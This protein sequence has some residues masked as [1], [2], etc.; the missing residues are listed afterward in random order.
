MQDG[1]AAEPDRRQRGRQP[2]ARLAAH[3]PRA[4]R[5]RPLRPRR[6]RQAA[7]AAGDE[8]GRAG[9]SDSL[10]GRT[11]HP[12]RPERSP[13]RLPG[14]QPG[15]RRGRRPALDVLLV[16]AKKDRIDDRAGV[17]A[18]TGRRPVVL[19]IEAFALANAYQMNYPGAHRPA[20]GAR[21]TSAAASRS[22]ACSN[23]ASRS[24]RATSPSAARC[25]STRCCA[26]SARP[27]ST[28]SAAKRILHGQFPRDVNADQVA[29]VLREASAQLVL[30]VR[31]TVDFY[32][33]TAPVEKLSRIVLS[34]G[35]WQ[36]VGLVDL[37]ASEFGAP[38]DVF[39]PFRR[40]T[41]PSRAIGADVGGP[42]LRGR[43]RLAMRTGRRPMIR[44]NLLATG[45]GARAAARVAA[46]RAALGAARASAC[47]SSPRRR[48][49]LV[50][51]PQDQQ[52]RRPRRA[53][54]TAEAELEQLKEAVKLVEPRAARKNELAERLALID[55]LRAAKRGAGHACSRP[56]AAACPRGSGSSKSSSRRRR[57]GRRP[58]DV[59]DRPSPTS[60]RRLQ[61][62]GLFKMPVEFVTTATE[63][64]EEPTSCGSRSRPKRASRPTRRRRRRR[65]GARR[66]AAGSRECSHGEELSRTVAA[67]PDDRLRAAL[68]ADGRPAPGRC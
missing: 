29:G 17:I 27:A 58:R 14:R 39:D 61:T 49:R 35:A 44:V 54:P 26:S 25:T 3:A 16:A 11:V 24:S 42:G 45:P 47:C 48:R 66:A 50:V 64:V 41:K 57:P 22:C 68:R 32:R 13:A 55:R 53:S 21:S 6:H 52:R 34:G 67:R 23:A 38:V 40:V 62:S 7:V 1:A 15:D 8:P 59:A 19:D 12:V 2:A 20:R 28:S 4:R 63:V 60:P 56:S 9:R 18:Q 65:H 30:E 51:V 46:A 31:K 33:A 5:Q 43:R 10:G 36:A 37:L